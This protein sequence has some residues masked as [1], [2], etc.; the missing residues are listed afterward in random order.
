MARMS[1]QVPTTVFTF[2]FIEIEQA[3]TAGELVQVD[4]GHG[5]PS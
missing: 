3:H 1:D 2:H 4:M 5:Q